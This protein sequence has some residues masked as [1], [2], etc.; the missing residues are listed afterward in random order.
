MNLLFDK[1]RDARVATLP[2]PPL[3]P[4]SAS[5]TGAPPLRSSSSAPRL[6][7]PGRYNRSTPPA[8]RGCRPRCRW[9]ACHL[10]ARPDAL[11]ERLPRLQQH[12]ALLLRVRLH[13]LER[14]QRALVHRAR[15]ARPDVLSLV[16]VVGDGGFRRGGSARRRLLVLLLVVLVVVVPARGRGH[17]RGLELRVRHPHLDVLR[18]VEQALVQVSRPRA[19]ALADLEIDVR[20][21]QHLRHVQN[22]ARDGDLEDGPRA[23]GLP[24]RVLQLREL[25]PREAVMRRDLEVFLVQRPAPV[26]VP[27]LHLH[28]DVYLEDLILRG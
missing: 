12:D 19:F 24:Q 1:S 8:P 2:L 23:L 3:A 14:Q 6:A 13:L 5:S 22:R 27:E 17:R 28:V 21:P 25:L 15:F 18:P 10:F 16:R 11:F 4:A 20:L 26:D 9:A 7:P